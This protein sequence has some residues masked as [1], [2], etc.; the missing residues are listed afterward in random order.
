MALTV[1][2]CYKWT[3]HN[4]GGFVS[5]VQV[6]GDAA[7]P[8]TGGTIGYPITPA[9]FGLNAFA[10]T[11]DF[12]STVPT[13]P[14][15]NLGNVAPAGAAGGFTKIDGTSSNLR[16]FGPTGTEIANAASAAGILAILMAFG[17]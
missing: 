5:I 14:Y 8:N 12:G 4:T 9:T 2:N 13:M 11:N 7:Y 15:V 10:A 6:T 17:T 1:A 16:F 3:L